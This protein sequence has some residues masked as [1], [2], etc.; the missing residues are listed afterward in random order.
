MN[1][2]FA[3]VMPEP[4]T[5]AF[6][7]QSG[8]LGTAI[9]DWAIGNH[10]GFSAFV[11]VG[12]M[13][14]VD[15]GDLIDYFG[16]DPKTRSI[17]LYM[18]SITDAR[19]FMSA[20]RHFAKTKP[21]VVVKAGRTARAAIGGGLAHR[22]DRRRRR[23]L[24]RRLSP[25][26]HRARQ[27]DRGPLRRLRGAEPPDEPPR[28]APGHPHQ[29]RRPRRHGHRRSCS[30][31]GGELAQ[32]APETDTLLQVTLPGFAAR[33][34]PV[35]I[36]GDADESR[37]AAACQALM[38][39]PNVDGVLAILTPQAMTH[40]SETARALIDVGRMHTTK[41]LLTSF[42]GLSMTAEAV[43]IFR[44]NHI[45]TFNTP[46]DAVR[47]YMYMVQ[48]TRNLTLPVRDAQRHPAVVRAGPGQGEGH[49]HD[50]GAGGL[51]PAQRDRGQRRP[52]GVRHPRGE[53]RPDDEPGGRRQRRP[54]RSG[55]RWR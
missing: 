23:P 14:D 53:D 26:R 43:E 34:N 29:R 37:Y 30:L 42:M 7:S 15:F 3:H 33:G 35:D 31:S 16:V 8:A 18:E 11:S 21:I 32:V 38:D 54:S 51:R 24:R 52:G 50:S 9:L 12:S 5:I 13:C 25:R 28:A 44:V 47:A 36:G 46:E 49:L 22:R 45:P 39:D 41:P 55:F 6:L 40:P 20:A 17:I 19:R 1:A 27:R 2:T 10:I 4:G 48:Y